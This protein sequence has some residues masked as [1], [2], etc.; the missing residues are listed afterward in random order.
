MLREREFFGENE[1]VLIYMAKRLRE[2]R[3]VEEVLNSGA[4]DYTVI[5][6]EYR[7][8]VFFSSRRIGAFFYVLPQSEPQARTLLLAAGFI[9]LSEADRGHLGK[10]ADPG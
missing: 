1:M 10:P 2:A 6:E 4:V 3:T 9:P 8:G 5:P 7:G